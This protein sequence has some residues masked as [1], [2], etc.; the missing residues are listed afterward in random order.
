MNISLYDINVNRQ[1]NVILFNWDLL[2]DFAVFNQFFF[3][4][5]DF[6]YFFFAISQK[7]S[8]YLDFKKNLFFS[9]FFDDSIFFQVVESFK[10]MGDI[11]NW[12]KF[13][14]F[15]LKE[16]LDRPPPPP[17]NRSKLIM[18]KKRLKPYPVRFA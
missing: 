13:G 14:F 6:T 4:F 5:A 2:F 1:K 11:F 3:D 12:K 9:F 17:S 15:S 10:K 18:V 16:K 8:I 7:F